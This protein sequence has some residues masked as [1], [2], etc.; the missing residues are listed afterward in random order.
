MRIHIRVQ[1]DKLLVHPSGNLT[2]Q[3]AAELLSEVQK[4]LAPQPRDI[5][6]D[7]GDIETISAGA[8]PFVFRIQQQAVRK[9]HRMIVTAVSTPVKR[10]L[11]ETKVAT[12]LDVDE[13][14]AALTPR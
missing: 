12:E 14:V 2:S 4:E 7:L 10:L 11:D 1:Q 5:A 9:K 13:A 6:L 8:L 3:S